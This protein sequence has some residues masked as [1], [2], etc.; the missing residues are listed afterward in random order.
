MDNVRSR[1]ADRYKCQVGAKRA[2]FSGRHGL[3]GPQRNG[4]SFNKTTLGPLCWER[5]GGFVSPQ[6][7]HLRACIFFFL[8]KKKKIDHKDTLKPATRVLWRPTVWA[9]WDVPFKV[10]RVCKLL[11]DKDWNLLNFPLSDYELGNIVFKSTFSC[12]SGTTLILTLSHLYSLFTGPQGLHPNSFARKLSN[13]SC[14]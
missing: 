6:N 1:E 13:L 10:S 12:L 3:K 5:R 8:S 7:L 11:N 9:A 14:W 4:Q 2:F